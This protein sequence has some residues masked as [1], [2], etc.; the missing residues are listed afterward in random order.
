MQPQLMCP[1]PTDGHRGTVSSCGRTK[2]KHPN[3]QNSNGSRRRSTES[4]QS[5]K[6]PRRECIP[7]GQL[8]GQR[9]AMGQGFRQHNNGG[10]A[11][12]RQQLRPGSPTGHLCRRR[13]KQRH[14]TGRAGKA[15]GATQLAEERA[16][17]T[18]PAGGTLLEPL[19]TGQ[20]NQSAAKK[21]ATD[22]GGHCQHESP[23]RTGDGAEKTTSPVTNCK[24]SN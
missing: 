21:P 11:P 20:P 3:L 14:P 7:F 1:T 24:G 18:L 10:N 22:T 6:A 9:K 23:Q 8:S 13:H 4:S 17:N 19:Q 16:G 15:D 12:F 2:Q 5:T